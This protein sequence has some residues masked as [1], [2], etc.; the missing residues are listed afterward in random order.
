LAL[1][2]PQEKLHFVF[3]TDGST[4]KTV[5]IVQNY[6]EI[7]LLHHP[8]RKGK[9]S[10]I[11]RAMQDISTPIVI[12]SDANTVVHRDSVKRLVQHFN[13]E[14][15]GGVSG[16][17][18]IAK[19][20]AFVN[21]GERLYWQYESWLKKANAQFFTVVGAAGELFAI[22]TAL[23]QPLDANVILDDFIIS[24]K[25]CGQG[26]RFLYEEGAIAIEKPSASIKEEQK[27]KVRI[28]AGCFQ[29]LVLT[30]ELLNPFKHPRLTFQYI[31]HRVL[32]W[33]V[34][35]VA[36]PLF[37]IINA[38][39]FVIDSGVLY[40]A[41][42]WGQC[43]FYFLAVCGWLA[44]NKNIPSRIFFV[45]YY[46]VFMIVSQYK[47]FARFVTKSQP[48]AWEKAARGAITGHNSSFENF[49]AREK[50]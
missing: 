50:H 2:Y 31:S 12:F 14:K 46:F 8:E 40:S 18:Q 6:S 9:A 5:S 47:G 35:P 48:A 36:L 20:V 13:N 38:Y 27:R 42:F 21:A 32:R 33:T 25:V 37:F 17:K 26:Y 19:E 3:V 41:L 30:K 1:D 15:V 11:N 43:F 39:F 24:A 10:A 44:A 22:R 4:D 34:C 16:E 23:Y 49:K 7:T 28:S 29:A 45:P